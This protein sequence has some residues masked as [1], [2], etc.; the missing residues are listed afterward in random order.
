[1]RGLGVA[2]AHGFRQGLDRFAVDLVVEMP[3]VFGLFK[4]PPAVVERFQVG[5]R[6]GDEGEGFLVVAENAGEFVEGSA[7]FFRIVAVVDDIDDFA[8]GQFLA[9][10]LE[11]QVDDELVVQTTPGFFGHR[12]HL[13][14]IFFDLGGQLML[15][16]RTRFGDPGAIGRELGRGD[17]FE[18]VAFAD[19]VDFQLEELQLFGRLAQAVHDVGGPGALFRCRRRGRVR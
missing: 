11:A 15:A 9:A 8:L 3:R 6:V 18:Q 17:F 10:D 7:A 1:M 13:A 5:Q 19:A 14:A 4:G 16:E 2:F 12:V